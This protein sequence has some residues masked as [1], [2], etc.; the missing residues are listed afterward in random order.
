MKWGIATILSIAASYLFMLGAHYAPSG[1][2]IEA[3]HGSMSLISFMLIP[4]I[5]SMADFK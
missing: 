5:A 4:I 2:G 1:S 3:W